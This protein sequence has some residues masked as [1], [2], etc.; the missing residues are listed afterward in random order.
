MDQARVASLRKELESRSSEELRQVS[1]SGGAAAKSPEELEAIRQLL[2]ERQ[3]QSTRTILALVSALVMGTLGAGCVW[4]Q[5][6]EDA[7]IVLAGVGAAI[8]G[9]ALWYLPDLIPRI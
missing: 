9:F 5:G 4:W 8:L 7:L 1:A 3:R 6:G 2:D